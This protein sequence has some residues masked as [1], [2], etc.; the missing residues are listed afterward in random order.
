MPLRISLSR[1]SKVA[2]AVRESYNQVVSAV[3]DFTDTRYY[4]PRGDSAES[5]LRYFFFMVAIDHRT[6][7]FKP[8]EGYIGGEHYHGADLLYRLGMLKYRENPDFFSPEKMAGLSIE[9]VSKW[10]KTPSGDV[11]WDPEIRVELLRDAG[12]KL[13][14][15]FNNSVSNFIKASGGFIRHPTSRSL[16]ALFKVFKAYSD[17]VEKKMFLFIKFTLRRGVLSVVDVQ[18]LEVP[19][20]NHLTRVAL[21][22]KLVEPDEEINEILSRLEVSDREDVELRAIIKRAYTCLSRLSGIRQDYLDDYLWTLGRKI[23]TRE[24]PACERSSYCPLSTVC[25][26]YR[27]AAKIVEHNYVNTYY[28]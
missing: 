4:P 2:S 28:Y 22:L 12:I 24:N 27:N 7:R 8:F 16:G 11:I 26:S 17:P 5:V 19:V 14:K 10:L 1:I 9:E 15:Y 20:D 21:R 13:I 23:C 6:S 25:V 3:E 18:N